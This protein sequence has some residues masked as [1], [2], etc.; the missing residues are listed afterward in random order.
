MVKIRYLKAFS[1]LEVLIVLAVVAILAAV[2]YPNYSSSLA[3]EHKARAKAYLLEVS[4]SQDNYLRRHQVYASD[5]KQ[6]GM[7]PSDK[8][9]PFYKLILDVKA[10]PELGYRVMAIPREETHKI[11]L[12]YVSLD[13]LGR[14][15]DN[16]KK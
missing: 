11:P 10:P 1:I 13:H 5:L 2:I 8:L 12:E 9:T 15:S 6:L 3:V 4:I 14:T 16:W 7:E